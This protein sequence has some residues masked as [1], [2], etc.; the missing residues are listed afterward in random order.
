ML[1]QCLRMYALGSSTP[2]AKTP[3]ARTTRVTSSVIVFTVFASPPPQP[4]GLNMLAPWGPA[5]NGDRK[6]GDE[7]AKRP[8]SGTGLGF[9]RTDDHA[10]EERPACFADVELSVPESAEGARAKG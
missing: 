1:F 5:E 6:A 8:R 10:E 4:R 7:K 3:M 9:S 2:M